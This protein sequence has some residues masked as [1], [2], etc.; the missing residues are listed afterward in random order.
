MSRRGKVIV[1]PDG[2][3]YRWTAWRNGQPLASGTGVRDA[4]RAH[5]LGQAALRRARRAK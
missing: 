1:E 4:Q 5:D 3:R 2:Q